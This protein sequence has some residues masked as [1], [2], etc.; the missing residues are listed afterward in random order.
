MFIEDLY[1]RYGTSVNG[2]LINPGARSPL[3]VNAIIQVGTVQLQV[4]V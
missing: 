1:S 2:K 3:P 4:R